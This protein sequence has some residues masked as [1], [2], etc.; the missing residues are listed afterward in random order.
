ML[1]VALG[2][3]AR[4]ALR[5]GGAERP[6]CEG[7][8]RGGAAL[9][10]PAGAQR[11]LPAFERA[12]QRAPPDRP[13]RRG[14]GAEPGRRGPGLE[15]RAGSRRP[16]RR[17]GVVRVL[18]TACGLGVEGSGWV[19]APGLVVTNAHVVA[20][21]SDTTVTPAGASS[22]LDATAVHYDPDERPRPAPGQRAR[23]QDPARFRRTCEW[24]AR[25]RARLSRERPF[26]IT[27]ARVGA[28]GPVVTQDSYGRGPITRELTALRGEVRSGNSGGP[29]VDS[30]RQ[31]DGDRVRGHHAGQA[32]WLRGP[33][34]RR[35]ECAQRLQRAGRHG[36]LHGLVT[37]F[38]RS[39]TIG[40]LET[41]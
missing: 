21:E 17:D 14:P 27:P 13:A 31:G 30:R 32:R 9:G 22:S 7:P 6:R 1:L 5:R 40:K 35:A 41:R 2:A 25:R 26:T 8:A 15:D 33:E 3:R 34:R 39:L 20:G 23:R 10:D 12:D 18:G 38:G 37:W 24:H 19:A 16:G 4:L 36:P 28:T 11:R 29:M